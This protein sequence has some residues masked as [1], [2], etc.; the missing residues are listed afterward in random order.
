MRVQLWVTYQ[1][2]LFVSS[3][4]EFLYGGFG[5]FWSGSE[6]GDTQKSSNLYLD[7]RYRLCLRTWKLL[8]VGLL[9]SLKKRNKVRSRIWG[10]TFWAEYGRMLRIRRIQ[11]QIH[12][13][14]E[15]YN[16]YLSSCFSPFL[17]LTILVA[18]YLV[19]TISRSVVLFDSTS[20]TACE[21]KF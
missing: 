20:I 18:N 1:T 16:C 11:I 10:K 14:A 4:P 9:G 12:I 8:Q 19:V 2:V 5:I 15:F 21:E 6:S 3:S 7:F 17:F 13:T